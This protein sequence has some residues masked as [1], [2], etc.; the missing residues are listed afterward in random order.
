MATPSGRKGGWHGGYLP[1]SVVIFCVYVCVSCYV[2]SDSCNPMTISRQ[3]PLSMGFPRQEKWSS[4]HA[5]LQGFFLT[6]G[7]NLGLPHCRQIFYHLSHQGSALITMRG[8]EK[9][10]NFH[11]NLAQNVESL[12]AHQGQP[13]YR[14]TAP[15]NNLWKE[16]EKAGRLAVFLCPGLHPV[17][18]G[19]PC[20]SY[21]WKHLFPSS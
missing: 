14:V 4:C 11:A 2:M 1:V 20:L 12:L 7:S 5:L 13:C 19:L 9:A 10:I 8:Q 21:V 18:V 6:Q 3:A 16:T 17:W 15:C